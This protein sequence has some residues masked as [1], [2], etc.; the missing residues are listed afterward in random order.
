[1]NKQADEEQAEYKSVTA[2]DFWD[3]DFVPM[4]LA[5]TNV[6]YIL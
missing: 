2:K 1:M 6:C 4:R 3:E 5:P